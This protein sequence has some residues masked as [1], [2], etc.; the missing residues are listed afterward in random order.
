MMSNDELF[1]LKMKKRYKKEVSEVPENIDEE[2]KNTLALIS[3]QGDENMKKLSKGKKAGLVAVSV[4]CALTI[5]MQTTFAKDLVNKIINSLSLSNITILED[6]GYKWEDRDIPASAIGKVFDEHGN[7]VEKITFENQE[8][9]YNS[10]GEQVLGVEPDGTL[11]TEEVLKQRSG[12]DTLI[13]EDA[14]KLDGYTCFDIKLPSYLPE[15]FT[16]HSANF[17][18]DEDNNGKIFDKACSLNF[19]NSKT[20][21]EIYISQNYISEGSAGETSFKNIEKVKVNGAD[22]I[23]GDEGI[24]WEVNGI[25]YLMYTYDLGKAESIKIA[26]SIQ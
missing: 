17:Y 22:A 20:G 1:D 15:G 23:V 18:K 16:F 3:T 11:L 9:L 26:E 10:E 5:T 14:S 4:V 24:V 12:D 8:H 13:V 25:R 7:I 6:E 19:V 21:K 2:F